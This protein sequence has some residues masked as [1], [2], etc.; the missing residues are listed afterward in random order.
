MMEGIYKKAHAVTQENPA[1]EKKP[2]RE[3]KMSVAQR[4]DWVAQKRAS[5]L[6]AQEQAVES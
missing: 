6:R 2:R 1:Y 3:V 5:F 4:K